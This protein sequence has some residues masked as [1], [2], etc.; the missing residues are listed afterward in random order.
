MPE[1]D[2]GHKPDQ[3]KDMFYSFNLGPIH[4]VGINTEYYYYQDEPWNFKECVLRQYDWLKNDL[5]VYNTYFQYFRYIIFNQKICK[6]DI[7][8]P[9][10]KQIKLKT[11]VTDLGL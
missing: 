7:T 6:F 10:R 3:G 2:F 11:G 5:Q 1:D 9:F 4:F 8:L